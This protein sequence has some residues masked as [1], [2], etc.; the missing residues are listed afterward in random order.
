MNNQAV[1]KFFSEQDTKE[2]YLELENS[3]NRSYGSSNGQFIHDIV[4][5]SGIPFYGFH[6]EEIKYLKLLFYQPRY[7][8]RAAELLLQGSLR[9]YLNIRT[10]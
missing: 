6:E 3:L 2:I 1:T 7:V 4:Q 5:I 8:K 9:F 10:F